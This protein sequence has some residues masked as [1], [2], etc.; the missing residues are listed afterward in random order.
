MIL[1]DDLLVKPFV[2]LI[3]ILHSM[4]LDEMYDVEGIQDELKETQM[5]YEL[6]ELSEEEYETRKSDLEEQLAVAEDVHE[7]LRNGKV[8]VKR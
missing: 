3:D 5:L 7:R 4:A 1:V 2:S 8:E 6:G